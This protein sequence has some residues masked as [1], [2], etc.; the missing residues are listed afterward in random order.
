[1]IYPSLFSPS[2]LRHHHEALLLETEIPFRNPEFLFILLRVVSSQ[3]SRQTSQGAR[4]ECLPMNSCQCMHI[5]TPMVRT[6]PAERYVIRSA[7]TDAPRLSSFVSNNLLPL[8]NEGLPCPAATDSSV[9]CVLS[10][11]RAWVQRQRYH[12]RSEFTEL[13]AHHILRNSHVVIHLAVVDLE[14][15]P[16]EAGKNGGGA[17]LCSDGCD[18]LAGYRAYARETA[19]LVVRIG[20]KVGWVR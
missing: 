16:H 13:M 2:A 11:A 19:E 20:W 9:G 14:I 7:L 18:S 17:C 15:E 12:L 5:C 3:L 8:P 6:R 4:L 1:M 10:C